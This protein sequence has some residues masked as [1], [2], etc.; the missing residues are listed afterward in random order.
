MEGSCK[1]CSKYK[2][3]NDDERCDTVKFC[4][5]LVVHGIEPATCECELSGGCSSN[6]QSCLRVVQVWKLL[7][8]FCLFIMFCYFPIVSGYCWMLMS[9]S[10]AHNNHLHSSCSV[11]FFFTIR[12]LTPTALMT[13]RSNVISWLHYSC[14]IS[15]PRLSMNFMRFRNV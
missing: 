12:T 9:L 3:E 5:V 15:A 6:R 1:F 14:K 4:F 13:D 8:S 10:F 2:H 7:F 11:C